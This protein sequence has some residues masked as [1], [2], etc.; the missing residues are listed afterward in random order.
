MNT[1]IEATKSTEKSLTTEWIKLIRY[2]GGGRRALIFLILAV[3]GTGLVLNWSWLVA[4][5]VA[6]LLLTL[7]P[8]AI[9]CGLGLCMNKMMGGKSCSTTSSTAEGKADVR[10][11]SL[12]AESPEKRAIVASDEEP[13]ALHS[14]SCCDGEKQAIALTPG[15]KLKERS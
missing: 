13:A 12:G 15:E 6:P 2:Y 1:S 4:I 8:C 14:Q 10:S 3:T 9:M 7:A 5:G 11:P